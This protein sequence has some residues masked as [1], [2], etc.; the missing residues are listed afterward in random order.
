MPSNDEL[1]V[2]LKSQY[3]AT[4]AMLRDAVVKCPDGLWTSSE[5]VNSPWQVAYHVL[6]FAHLY[7]RTEHAEWRPW[8]GHQANVQYED[9]IPGPPDPNSKLPLVARPYTKAEA[10]EFWEFV[11]GDVDRAVDAMDLDSAESGFSWYRVPKLEHQLIN[12]RHI[13]HHTAQLA[14]RLRIAADIGIDWVG[15][16]RPERQG[17]RGEG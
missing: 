2:I 12:L 11:D 8:T 14:T 3:H 5:H 15:A 6:F 10:L 17:A 4:L 9:G 7:S 16:R 1:R 13:E